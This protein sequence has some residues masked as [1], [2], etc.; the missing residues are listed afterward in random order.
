MPQVKSPLIKERATRLRQAGQQA[1]NRLLVK[2]IGRS[3]TLLVESVK[4]GTIYGKT[5]HFIPIFIPSAN[6]LE[7]GRVIRA[8]VIGQTKEQLIGEII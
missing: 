8:N 1:L 2:Q 7:V 4:A 3:V 6:S 5:D